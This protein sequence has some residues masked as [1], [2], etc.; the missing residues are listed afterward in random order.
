MENFPQWCLQSTSSWKNVGR[1]QP[2]YS[3]FKPA[4]I[5]TTIGVMSIEFQLSNQRLQ[6][7]AQ[8]LVATLPSV[9]VHNHL[10]THP[11]MQSKGILPQLQA[12]RASTTN[13]QLSIIIKATTYTMN[14]SFIGS[15]GFYLL[16]IL[17][18][19]IYH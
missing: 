7:M 9:P 13:H 1:W 19:Y 15:H 11:P 18:I 17:Y 16:S 5:A 14:S 8:S 10:T 3:E 2:T 6:T 4:S 12:L